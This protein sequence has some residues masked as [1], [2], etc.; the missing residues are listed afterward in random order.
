M[1]FKPIENFVIIKKISNLLNLFKQK[2]DKKKIVKKVQEE[3]IKKFREGQIFRR[4]N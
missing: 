3:L 4:N 1:K 2:N